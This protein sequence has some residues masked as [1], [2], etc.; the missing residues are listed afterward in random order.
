MILFP[1][2]VPLGAPSLDC[3]NA[4]GFVKCYVFIGRAI[5]MR[6]KRNIISWSS[7]YCYMPQTRRQSDLVCF[8]FLECIVA[9]SSWYWHFIHSYIPGV[10]RRF[11]HN[12]VGFFLLFSS[13]SSSS[14]SPS[15]SSIMVCRCQIALLSKPVPLKGSFFHII[16][17]IAFHLD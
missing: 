15:S 12:E 17:C 16:I 14:L 6:T 1:V 8:F 7:F 9:I 5:Q 3:S 4:S 10:L 13:S 2:L 11:L